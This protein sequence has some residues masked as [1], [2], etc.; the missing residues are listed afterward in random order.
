MNTEQAQKPVAGWLARLVVIPAVIE[1]LLRA[2]GVWLWA[3]AE[4]ADARAALRWLVRHWAQVMAWWLTI[5]LALTVLLGLAALLMWKNPQM[6]AANLWLWAMQLTGQGTTLAGNLSFVVFLVTLPLTL[7]LGILTFLTLLAVVM[8]L[9]I[10]GPVGLIAGIGFSILLAFAFTKR[11]AVWLGEFVVLA[12]KAN[13]DQRGLVWRAREALGL[14]G[15][16][17]VTIEGKA[18]MMTGEE[19]ASY[20]ENNIKATKGARLFLG[21]VEGREFY[22]Q[23]EKHVFLTAS[24]R[25]GKGRDLIVPNLKMYAHSVFV[26]DPK[27]E[28][29]RKTGEQRE[30]RKSVVAAFDVENLTGRPSASFNPIEAMRSGD[31]VTRADYLAEALVIGPDDH[32]HNSA[33]GLIRLLALHIATAPDEL[34][35]GRACDLLTLREMLTGIL[36]VTLKDYMTK[37]TAIEGLIARLA[38]SFLRTPDDEFG[39]IVTTATQATRWLDNPK[40]AELFKA[41]P[42]SLDFEQLRDEKQSMSIFVCLPAMIFSTYPQIAR[43]LTTFALDTMMRKETGRRR[44]VLFILDELAQLEKLPIVERAF[45]LGAGYG[46]QVWAVFQSIEQ[47]RKLYALDSLYGSAGFRGFFKLEDP[48][49]CEFVSKCASGLYSPSAVRHM[50]EF[51]MLTLLDGANPLYVERLGSRLTKPAPPTA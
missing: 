7:P 1:P 26:L 12:V 8:A 11:A 45:T 32:W 38:E 31:L 16:S 4:R 10:F 48:E 5:G 22:Y 49:S 33:R 29:C 13:D 2:F 41:G 21:Y 24:T 19:L 37:N 17:A 9:I 47:A 46:L 50:P 15:G 25:S 20:E 44:P 39:S 43:L 36:D 51:G 27:G 34:L 6:V 40:L 28:N 30:K 42:N 3:R 35:G 14:H 23:T 18:V